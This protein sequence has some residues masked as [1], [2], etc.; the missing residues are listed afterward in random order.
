MRPLAF[1]V[2]HW[3]KA[4]GINNPGEGTLSSYAFLL[5]L[6]HFLQTRPLPV[7]PFLQ[8]L[9]PNWRGD[10]IGNLSLDGEIVFS[11][12]NLQLCSSDNI[13]CNTYFLQPDDEQ[14]QMLQSISR[15][16]TQSVGELLVD[17]FEYFA[18]QFD[19]RKDIVSIRSQQCCF[20]AATPKC[21]QRYA[22]LL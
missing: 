3:S 16:N 11:T 19:F 17:F 9:S 6:I 22:K 14:F 8:S 10:S 1:L 15:R 2:K 4:R 12:V 18:S 5:C 21:L 7:L 13:A 20:T